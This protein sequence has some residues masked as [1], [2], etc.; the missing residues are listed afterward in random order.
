MRTPPPIPVLPVVSAPDP[1]TFFDPT[2]IFP[3]APGFVFED[4]TTWEEREEEVDSV[5]MH[6]KQ[7]VEKAQSQM[8]LPP[9]PPPKLAPPAQFYSPK[10]LSPPPVDPVQKKAEKEERKRE[11][12]ELEQYVNDHVV[13][14]RFYADE[15]DWFMQQLDSLQDQYSTKKDFY[16]KQGLRGDDPMFIQ[17]NEEALNKLNCLKCCS[18][19]KIYNRFL[20]GLRK[21]LSFYKSARNM[22]VSGTTVPLQTDPG[23]TKL[24][25]KGILE[26]LTDKLKELFEDF[27]QADLM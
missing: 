21:L 25:K 24:Y 12:H 19:F 8:N 16:Y 18:L 4:G 20:P 27:L 23:W 10:P 1:N 11:Y 6:C 13:G 22:Y 9:P 2:P 15:L 3:P 17:L 7:L 14:S 26:R 5:L